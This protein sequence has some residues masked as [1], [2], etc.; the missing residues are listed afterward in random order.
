MG[1]IKS[2]R[3]NQSFAKGALIM[4]IGMLMVKVIGAIFKVPLVAILGAEGMG[5]FN[6]AYSLYNPI[7]AL[8]TAG[9]PIAVARMISGDVARGRFRDVKKIHKISIPIFLLTGSIGLILMLIGSFF[10]AGASKAP[11]LIYSIFMLAP[12]VLFSCLI[13]IYKGYFEGL[14]N[15]TPTAVSEIVESVGKL[16]LGLSLSYAV[17]KYGMNEY[18]NFGTVF[19]KPF[20]SESAA[21]S[22]TLPFAS[23]GAVLGISLSSLIGFL[24]IY[25][26]FRT[27]GDSISKEE[28]KSS[29]EA[30]TTKTI[31]KML[32]S[33]SI[34][35]G[36]GA[37]IMNLAGVIDAVLIN[38]RLYDIM[39]TS[40][41]ILLNGYKGLIPQE[42]VERENT[43]IFLSGCFGLMNTITML[44]LAVT[45][46][47]AISALPFV[48][49]TW[50]QGSKE[51]IKKSIESILKIASMI[52]IP[53]GIGFS[54]LAYPI[55]DLVY[56]SLS[57]QPGEVYISAHIMTVS[58]IAVIFASISTPICNMLQAI[59]RA[60]LPVKLL[61]IG[62]V[63]KVILNYTLVGIPEVNI[64][65]ASVGTLV[66]Y[67]FVASSALYLLCRESKVSP[68]LKAIVI[69]PAFAGI[70]CG[71][72][73]YA[74]HGLLCYVVPYKVATILSILISAIVYIVALLSTQAVTDSDLRVLPRGEKIVKFLEKRNWL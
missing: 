7:Y 9:L 35:I 54:V 69:K 32:L 31:V 40:P 21:R 24:Y 38:R 19:G 50:V 68:D 63:I 42:V 36:L 66:C 27:I 8:A 43:H 6:G 22:A 1:N 45:Q 64:Q 23:A 18:A 12:T 5:Y 15:M 65:G 25:I 34:P 60:D 62:V 16:V 53:I 30:R 57:K 2:K 51:K 29:P 71:I 11:G 17:V 59:G 52:S 47:I 3:V 48:T 28:L 74:S 58:G 20:E 14:R 26:R 46:G 44:L 61:S 39:Q 10:Y 49:A 56:G 70:I 55:M 37:I 72:S 67:I 73:A 33:I 13:S 41:E 4:T